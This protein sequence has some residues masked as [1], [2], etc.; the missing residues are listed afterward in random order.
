MRPSACPLDRLPGAE[1][2][3]P[4]D[5]LTVDDDALVLQLGP[6]QSIELG[7]LLG[8]CGGGRAVGRSG[9]RGFCGLLWTA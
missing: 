1:R 5:V 8:K 6:K 2:D 7:A 4:R 9:G 3:N